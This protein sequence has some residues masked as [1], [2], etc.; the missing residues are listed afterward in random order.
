MADHYV[1]RE[2]EVACIAVLADVIVYAHA[3]GNTLPRINFVR[4]QRAY[5]TECVEAFGAAPLAVFGLEIAGGHVVHAG[6]AENVLPHVFICRG[7]MASFSNDHAE[8]ALMVDALRNF[9]T[10]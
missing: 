5:G 3:H 8:F 4:D 9:W 7:M 10:Q 1:E 6:V 2:D